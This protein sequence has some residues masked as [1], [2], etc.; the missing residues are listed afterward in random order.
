M[1]LNKLLYCYK[2]FGLN[3]KNMEKM[4]K[5]LGVKQEPIDAEEVVIKCKDKNLV[6]KNPNVIKVDMMGKETYQV[7]GDV[8]EVDK[9]NEEDVKIVI[10]QTNVSREKAKEVLEKNKGDIA[11]SILELKD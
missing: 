8:Q 1:Q 10:E 7:V 5:Q 11:K 2:M 4:M 3:P 6:I 9:I